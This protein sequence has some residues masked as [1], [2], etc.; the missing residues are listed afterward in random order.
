MAPRSSS[1]P[2]KSPSRRGLTPRKGDLKEAAIL[3]KAWALLAEKPLSLISIEDLVSE[4]GISRSSFYFYFESKEA[5]MRALAA[6]VADEIR[7]VF[8]QARSAKTAADVRKS[9]AG[10]LARWR[11]NGR[12]LRAMA[13]LVET[14]DALRDFWEEVTEE[15]LDEAA[16]ALDEQ[17]REGRVLP[18]PPASKDLVRA[19]FA[20]LWRTGYELSVRPTNRAQ[21]QRIID[22]LA[23][24]V[25]R[26]CTGT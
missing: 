7:A 8:A 18:A 25:V 26:S 12:V 13:I 14:D 1:K 17:R 20:M 15:L 10:Y 4:A 3:D 11:T 21:E 2:L 19:L 9:I 16:A 22:T 6:R 23:T 5:V 24:V